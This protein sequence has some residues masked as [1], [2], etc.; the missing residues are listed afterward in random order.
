MPRGDE[1]MASARSPRRCLALHRAIASVSPMAYFNVPRQG[2]ISIADG[3][4]HQYGGGA[5]WPRSTTRVINRR[6]ARAGIDATRAWPI[7]I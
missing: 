1:R 3:G 4:V 2:A 7:N 6:L 5:S